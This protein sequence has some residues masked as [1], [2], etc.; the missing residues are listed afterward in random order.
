MTGQNEL[1]EV[2]RQEQTL[3]FNQFSNE[4]AFKLGEY[5]VST[6]KKQNKAVTVNI[7]KNGQTI[8]HYAM[9]G[10]TP[11]Q[12]EWIKRK[13][14]VVLR[15]YHS[16]YYMKL[17]CE[18]KNRD[19]FQFYAVSPFE[20]AIHGGSFPITIAGVGAVGAITVSGLAQEEDHRLATEAIQYVLNSSK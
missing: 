6:V 9:D 10:V 11:D 2:K 1:E 4:D 5:I 12:D 17:Y 16:S 19:Y 13:S 7:V 15:H 20:F 3:I 18:L 8:F 14:N